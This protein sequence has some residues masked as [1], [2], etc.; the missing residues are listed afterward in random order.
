VPPWFPRPSLAPPK[1]IPRPLPK[2]TPVALPPGV[3]SSTALSVL[4]GLSRLWWPSGNESGGVSIGDQGGQ[5]DAHASPRLERRTRSMPATAAS[6]CACRARQAGHHLPQSALPEQAV[7]PPGLAMQGPAPQ[8]AEVVGIGL[9]H[10]PGRA[11]SLQCAGLG[12]TGRFEIKATCA[13]CRLP[14]VRHPKLRLQHRQVWITVLAAAEGSASDAALLEGQGRW[15]LGMAGRAGAT[16]LGGRFNDR[17]RPRQRAF[18]PGKA[19]GPPPLDTWQQQPQAPARHGKSFSISAVGDEKLAAHETAGGPQRFKARSG[20]S[21]PLPAIF[22]VPGRR[23]RFGAELRSR[24]LAPRPS[25][26]LLPREDQP[27]G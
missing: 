25:T 14:S 22:T 4:P 17:A 12:W 27:V 26:P 13:S 24:S 3:F 16:S 7:A 2:A 19:A 23:E 1:P 18:R 6:S 15:R 9:K 5:S 11:S 8:T 10:P 21:A 20:F